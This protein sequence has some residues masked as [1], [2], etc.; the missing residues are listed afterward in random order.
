MSLSTLSVSVAPQSVTDNSPMRRSTSSLVHGRSG[1]NV[2]LEDYSLEREVSEE[3]RHGGRRHRDRSHRTSQR[4]LTRYTDV[5]TGKTP[6][7]TGLA[8]TDRPSFWR[9]FLFCV[10][11]VTLSAD[12]SYR[13]F[14]ALDL[15][16]IEKMHQVHG[17]EAQKCFNWQKHRPTYVQV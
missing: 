8:E 3:S 15:K 6:A 17:G 5:D 2:R 7:H 9:A 1:R 11:T 14:N 16:F 10:S 12:V 4:S 13:R